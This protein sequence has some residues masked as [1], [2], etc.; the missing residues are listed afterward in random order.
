M[1]VDFSNGASDFSSAPCVESRSPIAFDI[2]VRS[3][4]KGDFKSPVKARLESYGSKSPAGAS[5]NP[6]LNVP[7]PCANRLKK[8]VA[9]EKAR[10]ANAK[11]REAAEKVKAQFEETAE[12]KRR[13]IERDLEEKKQRREAHMLQ[14]SS[15]KG[16]EGKI[17]AFL[18][19]ETQVT[20]Q[21]KAKIEGTLAQKEEK[22]REVIE[23]TQARAGQHNEKVSQRVKSLQQELQE[24][25]E[26]QEQMLESTFREHIMK[27]EV[28]A[29]KAREANAK[30]RAAAEKAKAAF[31]TAAESKRR[32]IDRDLDEKQQRRDARLLKV[33]SP[34]GKEG[35]IAAF[36]EQESQ[37]A[38]ER[39]AKIEGS[40]VQKEEKR[41]E[42]IEKAQAR[43][44]Q[45]NAKVY[46]KKKSVEQDQHDKKE[47]LLQKLAQKKG[48]KV[49][50]QCFSQVGKSRPVDASTGAM[51]PDRK[52]HI[53]E[54][55][56]VAEFDECEPGSNLNECWAGILRFLPCR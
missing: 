48:S 28:L 40:L 37:A 24:E 56:A 10:D 3:P 14:V 43:A 8:E 50:G 35:K 6:L 15:P 4:E 53:I 7:S 13:E 36:H 25:R 27:K 32:D 51:S 20:M 18:E 22:R 16:K 29:E 19:H 1:A 33:S 31:E 17:A 54:A 52:F 45:H 30:K 41:K 12:S 42:A 5:P 49:S 34:K 21:K 47:E 26:K 2:P 23:Q 9:A 44:V 39:K 55:A 38:M 46:Q 11:K